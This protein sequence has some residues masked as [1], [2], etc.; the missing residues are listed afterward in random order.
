VRFECDLGA[1]WGER[2]GSVRSSVVGY[3]NLT[4]VHA[5]KWPV[6]RSI[7]GH[8]EEFRRAELKAAST[9]I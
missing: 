1:I 7:T 6:E 2:L 9:S 4:T 3:I 5:G 8:E